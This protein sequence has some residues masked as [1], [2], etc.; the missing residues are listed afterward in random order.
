MVL[1]VTTQAEEHCRLRKIEISC[2]NHDLFDRGTLV[3]KLDKKSITVACIN[4]HTCLVF[5]L[6]R[7]SCG[8]QRQDN[9]DH[10]I[11]D[12]RSLHKMHRQ[13]NL[14]TFFSHSVNAYETVWHLVHQNVRAQDNRLLDVKM[15]KAERSTERTLMATYLHMYLTVSKSKLAYAC[16][17]HKYL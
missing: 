6:K 8:A 15:C 3:V 17:W 2:R 7:T 11:P 13:V 14:C 1:H 4:M 16:I 12:P 5:R 9:P 10:W